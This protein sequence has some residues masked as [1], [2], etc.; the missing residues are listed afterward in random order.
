[1]DPAAV[2][3]AGAAD[4]GRPPMSGSPSRARLRAKARFSFI[5][6]PPREPELCDEGSVLVSETTLAVSSEP[7]PSATAA[8]MSA[9]EPLRPHDLRCGCVVRLLPPPQLRGPTDWDMVAV[10]CTDDERGFLAEEGLAAGTTLCALG[11]EHGGLGRPPDDPSRLLAALPAVAAVEAV[12]MA[13]DGTETPAGFLASLP[14]VVGAKT[15]SGGRSEGGA[16]RRRF[17]RLKS[18]DPHAVPPPNLKH[19]L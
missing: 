13:E 2:G 9:S 11:G 4:G 10:V 12:A 18:T 15:S 1:M 17:G 3:V 7:T 14:G 8:A 5:C 6:G 19:K 16:G